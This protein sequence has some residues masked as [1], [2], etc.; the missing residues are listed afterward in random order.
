M[1]REPKKEKN[2]ILPG[3]VMVSTEFVRAEAIR[4]VTAEC[5]FEILDLVLDQTL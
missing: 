5:F 2:D 4:L 3:N 1:P